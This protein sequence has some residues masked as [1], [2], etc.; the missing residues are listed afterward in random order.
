MMDTKDLDLNESFLSALKENFS[1]QTEL[2]SA[3]E[4]ILKIE[5]ESAYRRIKGTVQFTIREMGILAQHLNISLDNLLVDDQINILHIYMLS[6]RI[7]ESLER[8][9]QGVKKYLSK[10]KIIEDM[11]D[12][13]MGVAYAHLP[14][15]FYTPYY[16]L[17]RFIYFKWSNY[18]IGPEKC[19]DFSKWKIPDDIVNYHSNVMNMYRKMNKMIYIWDKAIIWDLVNEI[20]HFVSAGMI[21]KE[22]L[23]EIKKDIHHMLNDLERLAAAGGPENNSEKIELYVSHVKVGVT[24]S[25]LWSETYAASYITTLSMM[26]TINENRA[27][28][29]KV[30]EWV[31]SMKKVSTLI[32]GTGDKERILFFK[33]QHQIVDSM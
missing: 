18:Y 16:T 10:I 28:C 2:I 5:R 9:A 15:E 19:K 23:A 14:M 26:S 30:R 20:K 4:D 24:Y 31:K 6:P 1:K 17:F 8:I 33:E 7:D 22:D 21:E 27:T 32:S 29:K 25:Y 3:V 11:P 13:E 12:S